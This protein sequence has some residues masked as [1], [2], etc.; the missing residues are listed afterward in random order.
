MIVV[1]SCQMIR[2]F[3]WLLELEPGHGQQPVKLVDRPLHYTLTARA[4]TISRYWASGT[5]PEPP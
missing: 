2:R 1:K 5:L 4:F 3:L